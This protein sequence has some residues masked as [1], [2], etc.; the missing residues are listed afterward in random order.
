MIRVIKFNVGR[1]FSSK[2]IPFFLPSASQL[3]TYL[4][5]HYRGYRP[6]ANI[7]RTGVSSNAL[8]P[9][10]YLASREY[11]LPSFI[12]RMCARAR[13]IR[14][15]QDARGFCGVHVVL[16]YAYKEYNDIRACVLTQKGPLLK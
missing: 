9:S 8:L 7:D 6:R 16:L 15:P 10:T 4:H 12:R 3:K 2:S 14:V 1:P 5:R 13:A 11:P